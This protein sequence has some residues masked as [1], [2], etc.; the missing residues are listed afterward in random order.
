M[1][2]YTK[3]QNHPRR[4][5]RRGPARDM[6]PQKRNGRSSRHEEA[7]FITLLLALLLIGV[8][9]P[10]WPEESLS[11][12]EK[13]SLARF[14][15]LSAK[16]LFSGEF[17]Q[18][19]EAY[20]ADQ[21]PF[22]EA[23]ISVNR[24]VKNLLQGF[25]GEGEGGMK[26][27]TA[28]KD[29]GGKGELMTLPSRETSP[30]SA[31]AAAGIPAETSAPPGESRKIMES[32]AA[33]GKQDHLD[34]GTTNLVIADGRAMEIFNYSEELMKDYAQRVNHLRA[35]LPAEK[36]LFSIVLPTSIAFYGTDELRT[37]SKS[38]FD[39]IKSVYEHESEGVIRV[40]A[41]SKLA[42]HLDE[43]I[44]YRTDHH[45]NGRGAYY[46][47]QAFCEAAGLTPTPLEEMEMT[48]PEGTF[49]GSLYGYTDNSPL[50]A[51]SADRA[52][53]FHPKYG[54]TNTYFSDASMSDPMEN[55][56]LAAQFPQDNHYLLYM[57]GDAPL[58]VLESELKNGKS[59]LVLKDSYGNAFVPY[60]LEQYEKVYTVDPRTFTDPLLPFIEAQGIQDVI[61]M[62][63]SFAVSNWNWLEGFD[64]ITGYA[65][66][67]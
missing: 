8:L 1:Q 26:L 38:T 48:Q 17:G 36:R 42:Q 27:I 57:G 4:T 23:L 24:G 45:W 5:V 29:A 39:A 14:P 35:A 28:R 18:K 21:F 15:E 62:N 12:S 6:R 44:Y 34:Y 59:I 2:Q 11:Q 25:P 7:V 30:D 49:L 52:E 51:N 53:F 65:A 33:L 13:R 41:Y 67:S 20:Y 63:Y 16:Q 9:F 60:L 47:Y 56:L 55:V 19:F 22:R 64:R 37:G 66:E 58:N 31:G 61:M 50:L 10:F 43:Y 32:Q 54:G 3:I 40:D 46:G